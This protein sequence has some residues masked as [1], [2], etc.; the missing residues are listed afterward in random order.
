[1]SNIVMVKVS[2]T[3]KG[4]AVVKNLLA[5]K[6]GADNLISIEQ[7]YADTM[8]GLFEVHVAIDADV[9]S[10][11]FE[12]IKGVQYAHPPQIRTTS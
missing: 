10:K 8:D 11:K 5:D 4:T 6:I 1:M 12:K 3:I 7:K 9:A 2:S